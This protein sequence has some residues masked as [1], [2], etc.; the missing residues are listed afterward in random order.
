MKRGWMA[1]E[2]RRTS[3]DKRRLHRKMLEVEEQIQHYR[4]CDGLEGALREGKQVLS[5]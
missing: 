4:V 5:P 2:S 1:E 3:A